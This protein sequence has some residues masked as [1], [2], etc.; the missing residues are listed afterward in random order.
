MRVPEEPVPNPEDEAIGSHLLQ[1]GKRFSSMGQAARLHLDG[2]G[3]R[4]TDHFRGLYLKGR[5]SLSSLIKSLERL[6][7]GVTELMVHPGRVPP[8]SIPNPFSQF[9][10]QD[11]EK[12]LGSLLDTGFQNALAERGIELVPFRE[13]SH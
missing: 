5:L 6:P 12:E 3:I 10:T 13:A 7:P 8:A 2:A 11:R 9:S 1:E 4:T